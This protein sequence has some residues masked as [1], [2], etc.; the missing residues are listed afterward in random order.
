MKKLFAIVVVALMATAV[1]V[2]CTDSKCDQCGAPKAELTEEAKEAGLTRE[3]CTDCMNELLNV[4]KYD[5]NE[6]TRLDLI[7]KLYALDGSPEVK[8]SVPFKD[9][10]RRAA[11]APAVIWAQSNGLVNGHEDGLLY[12]DDK[13]TKEQYATIIY[14]YLEYKNVDVSASED[15]SAYADAG[16]VLEY[17]VDA[18]EFALAKGLISPLNDNTIAPKSTVVGGAVEEAFKILGF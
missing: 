14:R 12:P 3:F 2:S 1:L 18:V 6:Y 17:S 4:G 8:G 15:L 9:V 13:L 16:D 7:K 11:Y 10:N 5:L